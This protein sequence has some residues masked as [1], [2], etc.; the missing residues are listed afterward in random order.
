MLRK[1]A[2]PDDKDYYDFYRNDGFT[3][4]FPCRSASHLVNMRPDGSGGFLPRF[5]HRPRERCWKRYWRFRQENAKPL[6]TASDV[7]Q[8]A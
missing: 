2:L 3:H 5:R 1:N 4:K 7:D 6:W 8:H